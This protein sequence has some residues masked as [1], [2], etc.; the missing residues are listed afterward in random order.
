FGTAQ[1]VPP[2][3][4]YDIKVDANGTVH[5]AVGD[6]LISGGEEGWRTLAL[7]GS[8]GNPRVRSIFIDREGGTWV[9]G[10]RLWHRPRGRSQF[11]V[12]ADAV[13]GVTAIAQAADGRIWVAQSEPARIGPVALDGVVLDAGHELQYLSSAITF[14]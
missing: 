9:G 12:L 5:A 11:T 6:F 14:D 7:E 2:G 10:A 3:I 13:R 4:P 1:G 8:G